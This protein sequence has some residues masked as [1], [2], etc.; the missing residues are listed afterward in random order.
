MFPIR[1]FYNKACN[2]SI[3]FLQIVNISKLYH[4][5]GS[6]HSTFYVW[7]FQVSFPYK[8]LVLKMRTLLF[9]KYMWKMITFHCLPSSRCRSQ[10]MGSSFYG[11]Q[12]TIRGWESWDPQGREGG[13]QYR[14]WND[15]NEGRAAQY[16]DVRSTWGG[17]EGS[18][19]EDHYP[20]AWR[21]VVDDTIHE[22]DFQ[23]VHD[24]NNHVPRYPFFYG[25]VYDRTEH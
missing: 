21:D 14:A 3:E 4:I 9:T 12:W 24:E 8:F 19:S 20:Y 13:N 7:S 25:N 18:Y 22:E 10:R 16:T 2:W 5:L 11:G 23:D 17:R 6:N 15:H 1:F